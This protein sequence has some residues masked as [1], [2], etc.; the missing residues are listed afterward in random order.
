MALTKENLQA[1]A[2]LMNEAIDSKL[3]ARLESIQSDIR[4]LNQTVAKIEVDHGKKLTAL[5]DAHVD[6]V[7]HAS[8]LEELDAK[9]EDHDHRIWALEQAAKN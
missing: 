4:K 7:R 1:I 3:D 5:F 6:N 2:E 9:A 8:T